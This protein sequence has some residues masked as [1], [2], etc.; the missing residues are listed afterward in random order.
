MDTKKPI[1]VFRDYENAP[2]T[3][4]TALETSVD[5]HVYSKSGRRWYRKDLRWI[6]VERWGTASCIDGSTS[7]L[8][9]GNH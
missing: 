8:Q 2:E 6:G 4:R 5:L 9:D 7:P 3:G 1:G